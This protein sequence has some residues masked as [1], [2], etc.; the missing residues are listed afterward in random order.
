MCPATSTPD[1]GIISQG[2]PSLSFLNFAGWAVPTIPEAEYLVPEVGIEPTRDCSH[3]ILSPARL[4]V[5]PLRRVWLECGERKAKEKLTQARLACQRQTGF[6]ELQLSVIASEVRQSSFRLMV[7]LISEILRQLRSLRMTDKARFAMPLRSSRCSSCF[8]NDL[9]NPTQFPLEMGENIVILSEAKNLGFLDSRMALIRDSSVA[10]LP[11]NDR[12]G[13]IAMPLR[14]S[15]CSSC[16]LN[17][18]CN[19]TQ[20]PLEMGE[21][22]V[23]LSEAKNLGFLDSHYG[24]GILRSLRSL[25]MTDK[26]GLLCLFVSRNRALLT[27]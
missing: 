15:R 7:L 24:S 16:F 23:I 6:K 14:F 22:I 13:E 19:P 18:L 8:L 21:N 17:D 12:Q 1:N 25:R 5:S 4:P 3:G 11:Q 10:S 2:G 26:A 9:C 27:C 20:F